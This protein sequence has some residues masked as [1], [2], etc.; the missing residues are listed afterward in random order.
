[1]RPAD[2]PV[3]PRRSHRSCNRVRLRLEE[4]EPRTVP[5]IFMPAQ[6]RHAYGFDQVSTTGAGQTIAIIDAY[7]NPTVAG[8]LSHFDSVFGLPAAS[9]T[10]ATPQGTPAANAGWGMEIDLDVEWAHAVA[11]GANI[12]LVEAKSSS[13]TDLLAAVDY[14]RA[15]A[16][17]SVISMSWGAGEFPGETSLDAH[18]T[19]P[20]GHQ[21]ITFVA[22]S[23]DN[24]AGVSWPSISPNVVSVGGTSLTLTSSGDYRSESA[25]SGSGGGYSPYEPEPAYQKSVQG[26]GLRTNPDVAYDANPNTGYYVY[27]GSYT[28]PGWY[29][30]GGTSAGAPQWAGLIAVANQARVQS[31]KTTLDG[32]S[33][34]LPAIYS[35]PATNFHDVTT[36]SNGY[37]AKVGYDLATGRGSPN[38]PLV[39]QSLVGVASATP[40]VQTATGGTVTGKV[41][42]SA[43]T[44]GTAAP[45]A[46]FTLGAVPGAV[47]TAAMPSHTDASAPLPMTV[48]AAPLVVTA[49]PA[50]RAADV[51]P[52]AV[53][54]RADGWVALTATS[55]AAP[56]PPP[57]YGE[58]QPGVAVTPEP[59]AIS[60]P[61]GTPAAADVAAIPDRVWASVE[62]EADKDSD[63]GGGG[64]VAA[65]LAGALLL[66]GGSW[67]VRRQELEEQQRAARKSAAWLAD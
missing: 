5:S 9:F 47:V 25:W 59:E 35:M 6:I 64:N 10:K 19:T 16:N 51:A 50:G 13:L 58:D 39:V 26:T 14:A 41:G 62:E 1:M 11:P 52:P 8:D 60:A 24:G 17:V 42:G 21:G 32:P 45:V 3:R 15:Q 4:L 56:A 48:T 44:V 31:G 66:A 36:G 46:D 37:S 53:S 63:G 33:Q 2:H 57:A 23:G 61:R 18:F 65:A 27:D 49:P 40:N 55:E 29:Q 20:K 30:V 34:T 43:H 28:T 67:S 54:R 38:V 12:L 7:D 22:S